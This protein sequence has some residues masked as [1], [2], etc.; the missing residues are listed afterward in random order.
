MWFSTHSKSAESTPLARG[1]AAAGLALAL[2][3]AP[4]AAHAQSLSAPAEIQ[5]QLPAARLSGSSKLTYFTFEVYQASLWVEPSFRPA[6][7]DKHAF[8]LELAYLRNLN[9]AEI[10]KRSI[11][12]M[13]RAGSFSEQ[14]AG[15]WL[16]K[17]EALFP[18]VKRGDRITGVHLPGKST[19]FLVN[20]KPVGDIA[21]PQFSRLFFSIWLGSTSSEPG[22]R[23]KLLGLEPP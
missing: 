23:L 21:D 12:E 1:L 19:Q 4:S 11:A 15:A 3:T 8:A 2:H 6:E 13:K 10:A 14:Q 7:F 16:S 5:A 18:D 22:M 9:G 20:G 17:M